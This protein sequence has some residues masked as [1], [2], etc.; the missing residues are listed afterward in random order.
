MLS[1]R[2][3]FNSSLERALDVNS[4]VMILGNL[5]ED[6]LNDNLTHL[7]HV[8]LINNSINIV[9]EP[10]RVTLASSTLIDPI[11]ISNNV[12]FHQ[13]GC[14]GVDNNI[15]DHKATFVL[16]KSAFTDTTCITRKEWLYSR[17]NF[18]LFNEM[19]LSENWDFINT[20][21]VDHVCEMFTSKLQKFMYQS[22][23]SKIIT[24]RP[25][26]KPWYDSV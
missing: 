8:L 9:T 23:P 25:N 2:D 11:I 6:L 3:D 13:A 12:E 20:L 22:I 21:P 4:K 5:N 19:V 1:L 24:V 7:K 15:S 14:L 16:I 26:D 17:A 10:T 18:H